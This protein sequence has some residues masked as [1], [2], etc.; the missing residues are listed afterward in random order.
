AHH[1]RP[2]GALATEPRGGRTGRTHVFHKIPAPRRVV[3][4]E[5]HLHRPQSD[6]RR[7][8]TNLSIFGK[9]SSGWPGSSGRERSHTTMVTL[10]RRSLSLHRCPAGA[11]VVPSRRARADAAGEQ[12]PHRWTRLPH[13]SSIA[14]G[15]GG[16][17]E[18]SRAAALACV[19]VVKCSSASRSNCRVELNDSATALSNADP[20]RPIDWVTPAREQ[21][22]AKTSLVYSP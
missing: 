22:R 12:R 16:R 15:R 5:Q 4:R 17:R 2:Q 7:M 13:R 21:A 18:E 14:P 9:C 10:S 11:C 19:R 6:S 1:T 8:T 3:V 20:V